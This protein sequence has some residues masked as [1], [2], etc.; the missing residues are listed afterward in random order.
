[1]DPCGNRAALT[2]QGAKGLQSRTLSP[3]LPSTQE[4][5]STDPAV[6]SKGSKGQHSTMEGS[7]Y[8]FF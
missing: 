5:P 6:Q 8:F 2:P 4:T 1:M 3:L 7:G